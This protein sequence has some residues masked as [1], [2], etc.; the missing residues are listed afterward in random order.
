M[1]VALATS[2]PDLDHRR[3]DEHVDLAVAEAAHDRVA[4][5]AGDAPVQERDAPVRERALGE[6]LVH[7]RRRLEV[8]L[9]RLLDHR[10]D[11]VRLPTLRHLAIDELQ[12]A[13]TRG[14]RAERGRDRLPARRSL[15]DDREIEVAVQRERERARDRRGAS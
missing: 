12:H 14:L 13:L 2:M 7:R 4:L 11:D 8:G 9:L 10:I 5:L 15:V 6:Q 3:R 1:T